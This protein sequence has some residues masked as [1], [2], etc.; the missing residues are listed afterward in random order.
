MRRGLQDAA[1][2]REKADRQKAAATADLVKF[3]REAQ[4]SDVP[5]TE[6]ARLAGLSRRSVYELLRRE[7]PRP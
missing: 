3:I 6:I 2:R 5:V 7:E 1:R 4:A